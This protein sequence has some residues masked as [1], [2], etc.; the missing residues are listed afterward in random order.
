MGAICGILAPDGASDSL[1]AAMAALDAYGADG[2]EWRAT[3]AALGVRRPSGAGGTGA[4]CVD[5]GA[6]ALCTDADAGLVVAADSRLD[7]REELCGAL[8]IPRAERAGLADGDLILRAWR[9]WDRECPDHLLGDFAFAIWDAKQRVLVCARD[10]VG[11]RPLYYAV[12][13]RR[14]VFTSAVEAVLAVP[15]VGDGL[16]EATVAAHLT[17]AALV[18]PTRTFFKAVRKL[19]PGHTLT[20]DAGS[21]CIARLRRYWH[22]ERTPRAAPATDDAYGEQLLHLYSQ[23]VKARLSG[24][25]P[26]GVH[27]SG[28]LDS[29]GIAVLAA[30][31]LRRQGRPP[32]LA[33][34]WLPARGQTPPGTVGTPEYDRVHVVC[35]QEELTV[36]HRSPSVGD[37]AALLSRDVARPGVHVHLNEEVV[38]RCAAERGVKVLLSGWGGDEGVSFDGRGRNAHLLLSGRWGRLLASGRER[39]AHPLRFLAGVVLPLVHPRLPGD[40]RRLLRGQELL[41]RRWLIDPAFARR[42]EPLP[43]PAPRFVGVR[44][45]QRW[46]LQAGHLAQRMEGWAAGGVRHGIEYRYP[47]LDRRLLEFALSLP[48]EQFRHGRWN[49]WLM[50]RALDPMLPAAVCWHPGKT[51]PARFEAFVAAFAGA[52]PVVR[53]RLEARPEPPSRAC[54]IDMPR[55][56]EHLDT[57][58]F[59]ARPQVAP[60]RAALQ[61][62]DF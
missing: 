61:L 36:F 56:L 25:D 5:A 30:R 38:Q 8:G 33:F 11:T 21:R 12:T 46:L 18:T 20:V 55:L 51:D 50:R 42:A 9:R 35:E 58:R 26:I 62:L 39:G 29:S 15:F 17:R 1:A 22:P 23:A 24:A 60:I 4:L 27:L 2:G 3:G 14:F 31:E 10:H 41:H 54:Y 49:R 37:M 40:L 53:R 45:T 47:L 34:S 16:D 44:R 48:P 43:E 57:E 32:P 19:P 52:L 13:P 28:G 7:N 6:K 59:R